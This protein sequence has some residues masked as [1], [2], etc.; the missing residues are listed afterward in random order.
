MTLSK[1]LF[2]KL[3]NTL[4]AKKLY[5]TRSLAFQKQQPVLPIN[6][7]YVRYT[8]LELCSREIRAKG[9]GGN[10][11][12]LGVY[13][14]DFA[15]RLNLLFPERKLYLFDTFEGFHQK[16]IELEK[17]KN[18][19]RG[20][21]DFSDT[22]VDLVLRKMTHPGNCIVRKGFFPE[23]AAGIDDSFCFVNIDTDL[24]EP[25]LR[26]LEFFYPRLEKGGYIFVHDFNNDAYIGARQAVVEFCSANGV[27]YVPIPDLCGTVIL[28]K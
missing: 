24:Y 5:L 1:K 21:Q 28:T 18:F 14:G 20:E 7:D 10:V 17:A 12:E 6:L 22:S 4:S 19:S 13:K 23:T 3:A 16:D 9:L 15:K 8:T 26:G 11:A 2:R 25:I 27:G